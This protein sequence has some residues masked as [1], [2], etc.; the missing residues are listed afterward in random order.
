[1]ADQD[2]V[3]QARA[4]FP[5]GLEQP[6]G[7]LRFGMDA[8]LLAAFAVRH[9]ETHINLKCKHIIA[10][11]L[12]SGCGAAIIALCLKCPAVSGLGLDREVSL[13]RAAQRNAQRLGL[14]SRLFFDVKDLTD[15]SAL[16]TLPSLSDVHFTAGR[17][18][19]VLCNPPFEI[20]GRPSHNQLREHALRTPEGS[21]ESLRFFCLAS[22]RLLRHHGFFVCIAHI[23]LL[24]QLCIALH[25]AKLGIQ[26]LL[27]VRPHSDKPSSRILLIAR[28]HAA[29]N[30]FL[31]KPLTLHP[32]TTGN[33]RWTKTALR[34][35]SWLK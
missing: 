18:D 23:N 34:F 31:E 7:S 5:R 28:L 10:A 30:I 26:C 24:P 15:L 3:L 1:M 11:E 27:P 20:N 21:E 16:H 6:P 2:G 14:S 9:I 22:S 32:R 12:G 8:L 33:N 29:D 4:A 19:L 35:C 25:I 17:F 13:I